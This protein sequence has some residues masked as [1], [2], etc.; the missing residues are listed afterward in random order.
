MGAIAESDVS[1]VDSLP[2]AATKATRTIILRSAFIGQFS[3]QLTGTAIDLG[4][5]LERA[6]ALSSAVGAPT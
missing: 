3:N 6:L 2:H 1:V 4:P 5:E